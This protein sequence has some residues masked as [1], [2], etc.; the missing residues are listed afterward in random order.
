MSGRK[1]RSCNF[2]V[3]WDGDFLRELLDRT[4]V[5]KWDWLAEKETTLLT[6]TGCAANNGSKSTPAL[7]ADLLGDWREE[8]LWRSADNKEL[9]VYTTTIPSK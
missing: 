5:S 6:A 8:V 1:P 9:R 7:C 4:T 3:W 2:A